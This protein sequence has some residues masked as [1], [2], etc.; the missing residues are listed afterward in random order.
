M[1][2]VAEFY[3]CLILKVFSLIIN[4]NT[5]TTPNSLF[6]SSSQPSQSNTKHQNDSNT[7]YTHHVPQKTEHSGSES[8][9]PNTDT[10]NHACGGCIIDRRE[11]TSTSVSDTLMHLSL[12]HERTNT[13]HDLPRGASI[14]RPPPQIGIAPAIKS[15]QLATVSTCL[16]HPSG[17]VTNT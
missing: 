6:Y 4:M 12:Q 15:A 7:D 13:E 16:F 8:L 10:K 3:F 14:F 9:V 11:D 17:S 1:V 5:H 2:V